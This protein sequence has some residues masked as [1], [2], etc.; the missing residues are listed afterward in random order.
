MLQKKKWLPIAVV[1]LALMFVA[2]AYLAV[3]IVMINMLPTIYIAGIIFLLLCLIMVV[4]ALLFSGYGKGP[5]KKRRIKRIIGIILA[6][7]IASASIAASFPVAKVGKTVKK[8]TDTENTLDAMIG[9][10]VLANDPAS[11]IEDAGTY[12]F[13]IM[14]D[15]DR[16]NTDHA[17]EVINETL[18]KTI[19]TVARPSATE[20]AQA[21]FDEQIQAIIMNET[22]A[23]VLEGTEEFSDFSE[24]TKIIYEIPVEKNITSDES[25]VTLAESDT[26][27]VAEVE[28]ELTAV[29]KEP[30]VVYISGSDTR[31]E[32][33]KKSNSDVNIIAAVNPSTKQILL[34][35]TPRDY[36]I[37]NPAG[38]GAMDKLTH[39][40][41]YGVD[42]SVRALSNLYNTD[43]KYYAQINFTGLE[44]LVDSIGGITVESANDFTTFGYT[45]TKGENTLNGAQALAF[46]RERHS[47]ASGDRE[48]GKNQMRVI[49]AII[50]KLTSGNKDVLMNFGNILNSI[51]EMFVTD[52]SPDDM[53][54]LI[55]MQLSDMSSWNIKQYSVTGG[56]GKEYTYSM[57]RTKT[58]VMYQNEEL[59]EHAS[60]LI[61]KVEAGEILTDSD[62]VS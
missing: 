6:A 13:G 8:V 29:T 9:V 55:K 35:N 32:I 19:T 61:D 24:K 54:S 49:T 30:F 2:E 20:N 11:S 10:Y 1:V 34:L 62:L 4:A 22:Y 48:R 33:L 18:G 42:N 59:V 58:Y 27:S 3:R 36:Y 52:M 51:S 56:D 46:S 31:S 44:T 7:V 37:P 26:D 21:L 39:C 60:A 17:V 28:E 57:P 15:Y 38:D 43:I 45:F 16:E 12:T 14:S 47:F 53:N 50:N 41:I 25:T 5:E 40:G 23:G